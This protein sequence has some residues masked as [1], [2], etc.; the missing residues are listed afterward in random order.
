MKIVFIHHGQDIDG[1]AL[2][3]MPLGGTETAMILTA[4]ALAANPENDVHVFTATPEAKDY[5]GVHYHPL[6]TLGPWSAANVCDVLI[7]IRQWVPFLFPLSARLKIYFSPDAYDQ[8]FLN[9][10]LR[11]A[12]TV[13]GE[14]LRVPL[15]TP[16]D[17]LREVDAVYCVGRWQAGTF[18]S[19][20]GF[21]KDKLHVTANG[22]VLSHFQP[23]PLSERRPR[24]MYSSTP[25]RGLDHLVRYF[26]AIKSACPAAE[27]EVCS[28]MKVYGASSADEER[29]YGPLFRALANV[30][31]IS[32]GSILQ[33]R[34][35]EI[36]CGNRV[37]AYPNTFAETF[38]ISVLEA[39]AAGL[40]I[41][42]SRKGALIERV[43]HG[44]DGFLID[45]EPGD[46]SYD[47][48]FIAA[49]AKLLS[50]DSLWTA[51]SAA[52]RKKSEAFTYENLAKSWEDDFTIRLKE[53][54]EH[55]LPATNSILNPA[56][57]T[58]PHP[59][60]PKVNLNLDAEAVAYFLR[61]YFAMYGF[62]V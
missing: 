57:L 41:V 37:Y 49:V 14:N 2:R 4:A 47:K 21:P 56:A 51:M 31:A 30:G 10:G 35:A 33:S 5:D 7:C 48:N 62:G 28:G 18:E 58:V 20:L 3:R 1:H 24:V 61:Q 15:F 36:M 45:G 29:E 59:T 16:H 44:V 42:T 50:D 22:V 17:F 52:A 8:P 39:Q 11:V 19:I 25:F 60:R 13:Q 38:C 12:L 23:K 26:P 27:L 32:H 34:L 9:S 6:A 53:R 55:R 46:A 54:P 40:P 43:E